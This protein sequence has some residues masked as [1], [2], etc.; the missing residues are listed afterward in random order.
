[1]PLFLKFVNK[2]PPDVFERF[3]IRRL[4]TIVTEKYM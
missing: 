2:K 4:Y 3:Q 1:M